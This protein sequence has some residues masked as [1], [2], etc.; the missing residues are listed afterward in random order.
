MLRFE[1][2][3]EGAVLKMSFCNEM[4]TISKHHWW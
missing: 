2:C 3:A 4:R 1:V